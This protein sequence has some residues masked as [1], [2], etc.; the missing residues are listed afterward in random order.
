PGSAELTALWRTQTRMAEELTREIAVRS[1]NEPHRR[2]LLVVA[3]RV[4]ATRRRDAD[5]A[6]RTSD[7][8]PEDLLVVQRSLVEARATRVAYGDLQQVIWQVQTFGF[9]LAEH[10]VRQHSQVHRETLA[11]IAE[12]G[13]DGPLSERAVEV[14]DTFRAIAFVQDR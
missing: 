7:E 8:L 6:Y 10:E 9:H 2:V 4:S 13:V 5:L 14:L 3:E 11:E 1:P 12:H